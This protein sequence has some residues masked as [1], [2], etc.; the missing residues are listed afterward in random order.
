VLLAPLC[1]KPCCTALHIPDLSGKLLCQ[2]SLGEP[3]PE[4]DH[5]CKRLKRRPRVKHHTYM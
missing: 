3:E 5:S 2:I 1:T 4:F